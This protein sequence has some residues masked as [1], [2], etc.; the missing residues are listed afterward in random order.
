MDEDSNTQ[1]ATLLG[2]MGGQLEAIKADIVDTKA[3]INST[4]QSLEADTQEIKD[5]VNSLDEALRGTPTVTGI[6]VRIDRL[7]QSEDK[8]S[9][10]ICIA[11]TTTAGLLLERLWH[12]LSGR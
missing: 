5:K 2:N 12:F 3:A 6:N 7:E 9:K 1:L 4:R 8:R 11:I 10:L